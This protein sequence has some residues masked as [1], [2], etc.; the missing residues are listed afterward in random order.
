MRSHVLQT[1]LQVVALGWWLTTMTP[2]ESKLAWIR[3]H[4]SAFQITLIA[5]GHCPAHIWTLG[6]S[7]VK[8][9]PQT[10]VSVLFRG[11]N[12]YSLLGPPVK[13]IKGENRSSQ[14]SHAHFHR[15]KEIGLNETGPGR[16][17]FRHLPKIR[18]LL[19]RMFPSLPQRLP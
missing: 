18:S 6:M 8:R 14:T 4:F 1:F 15:L 2:R 9:H 12:E 16:R 5:R 10:E 3:D 13:Q 11:S 7:H 19:L 17:D